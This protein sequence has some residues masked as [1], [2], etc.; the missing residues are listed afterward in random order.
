MNPL[1]RHI[2]QVSAARIYS[3]SISTLIMLVTARTLGPAS[4]GILVAALTWVTLFANFSGFSIEQ[5]VHFRIQLKRNTDWFPR[6]CG[7]LLVLGI[8]LSTAAIISGI[9]LQHFFA[10]DLFRNIP[11]FVLSL[12]FGLLP[13]FIFEQYLSS[14][15]AAANRLRWYNL[16]QYAGRSLW[17]VLIAVFLVAFEFNVP[18]AISAQL[19]GQSLLVVIAAAGLTRG[20]FHKLRFDFGEAKELL[21]GSAKLHLNSIGAFVLAQSAVLLLNHFCTPSEVAWYQVA[22]QI[23]MAFLV[24]PYAASTVFFAR[25]AQSNPDKVWSE[26]KRIILGVTLMIVILST[27][28]FIA[29]PQVIPLILGSLYS[30]VV[31]IFRWLL[32]ILLGLTIAQ[33]MT[34]QWI[35]RGKFMWTA[36][37]TSIAAVLNLVANTILIPRLHLMGAVWVSLFTYLGLTLLTQLSFAWWCE[38]KSRQHVDGCRRR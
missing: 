32:P 7:T 6:I 35:S 22:N 31:G 29:A 25:I 23:V 17:L 14:L 5:V 24:I 3:L 2:V 1:W 33:L 16:A 9:F 19:C 18:L 13:L 28:A 38:T 15:L 30:P 8:F 12:A 20:N 34:P 4:Q 27:L 37:I 11:A 26:Q 36:S 21:K 10:P